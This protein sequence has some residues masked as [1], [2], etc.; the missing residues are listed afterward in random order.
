[1]AGAVWY[2]TGYLYSLYTAAEHSILAL[3]QQGPARPWRLVAAA[4]KQIERLSVVLQAVPLAMA[5]P[6]AQKV[7]GGSSGGSSSGGSSGGISLATKRKHAVPPKEQWH[8]S[9]KPSSGLV[10]IERASARKPPL[11][12]RR[13][14]WALAFF[15]SQLFG[16]L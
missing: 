16:G 12:S 14:G 13:G 11:P 1:M 15:C 3:Q 2:A 6:I 7:G 4:D 8:G 10:V 5:Q 9:H